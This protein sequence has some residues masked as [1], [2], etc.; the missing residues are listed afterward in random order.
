M[1]VCFEEGEVVEG[2]LEGLVSSDRPGWLPSLEVTVAY[3]ENG[4]PSCFVF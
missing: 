1:E 3:R 4:F 2:F